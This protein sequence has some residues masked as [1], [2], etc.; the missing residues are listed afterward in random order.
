MSVSSP[1]SSFMREARGRHEENRI[2]LDTDICK[3]LVC[4]EQEGKLNSRVISGVWYPGLVHTARVPLIAA[5]YNSRVPIFAASKPT[6]VAAYPGEFGA[7]NRR[8]E[9]AIRGTL[10]VVGGRGVGGAR[11]AIGFMS[12]LARK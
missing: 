12:R 10:A 3:D 11:T 9:A 7:F 6:T 2:G 1:S 5:V 8:G 4:K